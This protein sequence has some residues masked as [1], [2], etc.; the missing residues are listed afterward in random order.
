MY[1]VCTY[2]IYIYMYIKKMIKSKKSGIAEQ[3]AWPPAS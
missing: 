3:R 1:V 2:G